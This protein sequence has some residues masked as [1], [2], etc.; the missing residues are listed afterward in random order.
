MNHLQNVWFGNVEKALSAYLNA[1]LQVDL[2]EID[3]KLQV[4]ASI[5]AIICAVDKELSL[6]SNYPKGHGDLFLEWICEHYPGILLMHV[7]HA[8]GSRQDLC[9]EGSLAIFMNYP[10]YVEFL[11]S[12]LCKPRKTMNENASILQKKIICCSDIIRNDCTCAS[13]VNLAPFYLHAFP[14][15]SGKIT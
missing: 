7:E 1:I 15:P 3:P 5:N 13:I 8:A 9:T 12:A 2:D 11:D 4:T 6:S 10:F 14:I